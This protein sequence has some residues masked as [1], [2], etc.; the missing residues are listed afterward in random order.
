MELY[1]NK[2]QTGSSISRY[3]QS[4]RNHLHVLAKIVDDFFCTWKIL[5]NILESF[6]MEW[7][8]GKIDLV[9]NK[10][11]VSRYFTCF[12]SLVLV[13]FICF[14]LTDNSWLSVL[15][16]QNYYLV[17]SCFNQST[18]FFKSNLFL[19]MANLKEL[20]HWL[21]TIPIISNYK[22]SLQ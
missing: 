12:L 17:V 7:P 16:Q 2:S 1:L 5:L 11:K 3:I 20:C 6:M 9:K 15:V 4:R 13:R 22:Q 14:S 10:L 8:S 21:S 18:F 19:K